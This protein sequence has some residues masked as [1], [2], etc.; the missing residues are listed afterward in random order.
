MTSA[1]GNIRVLIVEDSPTA[2]EL[3]VHIFGSA[4]G[5][6]VAGVACDGREAVDAIAQLRPDVVTMDINMPRM[7]G[8]EATRLIMESTPTPV[9]IVSAS[10]DPGEV[11]TTFAAM[12]AGAI[13]VCAKPPAID[14]PGFA[15]AVHELVTVSRLMSEVKVVRRWPARVSAT[16][17][18][19]DPPRMHSGAEVGI[20]A[21]GASTGGPLVIRTILA[22]LPTSLPFP[23][24]VVQHMANGFID[25][26]V[27]WLDRSSGF[28]VEKAVHGA[29]L[30]PAH[31]YIAPD[32]YH[33]GVDRELRISLSKAEA[34]NGLRP[35]VDHLFRSVAEA[36]GRRTMAVIL[37]GMG[38]DGAEAMVRVRE[39]GGTTIAQDKGSCV[40]HGMPGEAIKLGAVQ[41]ILTPAQIAE[42]IARSASKSPLVGKEQ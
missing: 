14:D 16:T 10:W 36:F 24:L 21:I 18:L 12:E 32:G 9:V 15:G 23:I 17:P 26:F 28:P 1:N 22:A 5:M 4:G 40:V 39:L 34:D 3:L 33:L 42:Q 2:R 11:R 20:V 8:F 38:C 29:S 31:A 30:R 19:A 35:S 25:G 13:A 6:E 37:S 41:Q 7:N 27:D